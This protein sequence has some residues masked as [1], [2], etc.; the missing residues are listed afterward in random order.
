MC[1]GLDTGLY[2]GCDLAPLT[3]PPPPEIRRDV[4]DVRPG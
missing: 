4:R 2:D 1:V 3:P